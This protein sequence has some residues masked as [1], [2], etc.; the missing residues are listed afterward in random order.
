MGVSWGHPS[1][2]STWAS[3]SCCDEPGDGSVR[4]VILPLHR[5]GRTASTKG[6]DVLVYGVH[7]KQGSRSKTS[8]FVSISSSRVYEVALALRMSWAV[9]PWDAR[10]LS[11]LRACLEQCRKTLFCEASNCYSKW[12]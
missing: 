7:H 8:W 4:V 5:P 12:F 2:R 1:Q 6:P 11:L 10:R 9:G 3:V